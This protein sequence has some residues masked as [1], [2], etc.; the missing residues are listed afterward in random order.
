MK[1]KLDLSLLTNPEV[2]AVGALPSVSDHQFHIYRKDGQ[3]IVNVHSL[4][5]TWRVLCCEQGF[6]EVLLSNLEEGGPRML[7]DKVTVPGQLEMSYLGVPAQYVNTQYPW[8]GIER[9]EPGQVPSVNPCYGYYREFEVTADQLKHRNILTFHG[10]MTSFYVYINGRFV[11]YSNRCTTDTSFDV[12]TFLVEGVNHLAVI[13]FHFSAAFWL[14]DQDMWRLTGIYRSVE[15]VEYGETHLD[16]IRILSPIEDDLTHGHLHA[17]LRLSGQLKGQVRLSLR[18]ATD[19][20]VYSDHAKIAGEKLSFD[21]DLKDLHA[22]SSETPYLYRLLVT[23][24]SA[25]DE[26]EVSAIDVG[27]R[28]VRI[29]DGILKVNGRRLVIHGVNRHEWSMEGGNTLTD[30]EILF[31]VKYC[32]THNINAIRTCHYPN[33]SRLYRLCDRYGIYLLDEADL[34]THGTWQ[35]ARG[36]NVFERLKPEDNPINL[37]AWHDLILDR[38][39]SMYERD[40]N[41]PSVIIWSVG[42][43]SS[44]G[45]NSKAAYDYLKGVDGTRPVHYESCFNVP[46]H[47]HD[48]DFYSRMYAKPCQIDE[49]MASGDPRPMIECEYE[50][51]MG[52]STGN[53]D[54]YIARE[55]KYPRYCGGFIWDYIDQVI[56]KFDRILGDQYLYGGD[57]GDRPNDGNFNC[58]GLLFSRSDAALSSK[59]EMARAA[60]AP[61]VI[62]IEDGKVTIR[63]KNAFL[64][65]SDFV[66]KYRVIDDQGALKHEAVLPVKVAPGATVT[67]SLDGFK[68]DASSDVLVHQVIAYRAMDPDSTTLYPVA[69]GERETCNGYTGGLKKNLRRVYQVLGSHNVGL[70][71]SEIQFLQHE[72]NQTAVNSI[73]AAG[74]EFLSGKILPI[75]WRASTDNDRGNMFAYE[76]SAFYAASKFPVCRIEDTKVLKNGVEDVYS[77]PAI[78]DLKVTVTYTLERDSSILVNVNY[79]GTKLVHSL[80]LIG[81]RIPLD[82]MFTEVTY[83]GRGPVETYSD[84]KEGILLGRYSLPIPMKMSD[85]SELASF[86]ELMH[87]EIIRCIPSNP[88][89]QDAGNRTDVHWLSV[90]DLEGQYHLKITACQAPL[91]VKILDRSPFDLEENEH[92]EDFNYHPEIEVIGFQRGVGGDDS[93]GAPVYPEYELPGEMPLSF[94]FRIEAGENADKIIP[95]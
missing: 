81:L 91:Q 79:S 20:E 71:T 55:E 89:P 85:D 64:D 66:F 36:Q 1:K 93:W 21:T 40:K 9:L 80:P 86:E 87:P 61:F 62:K 46:G 25:S 39:H 19:R 17:E 48:S 95:F 35:E 53:F 7:T 42:N 76:N 50:H 44:A 73:K 34:E 59:G 2:Y 75:L 60:Y 78:P 58:N 57:F 67:V 8:D 14:R 94:S 68:P 22:W 65:G 5:G 4:D 6:D 84:R 28:T 74:V 90:T 15:L 82:S 51:S 18:D 41:H 12:T 32:R 10:V 13:V 26:V 52:Q 16:N 49:Y 88:R 69:S 83:F 29:E 70:K 24:A 3:R 54:L 72:D 33:D 27:F 43:E 23:V 45:V 11:G 38:H 56:H 37:P 31:D 63:N 47:E 92:W 77:F 30:E